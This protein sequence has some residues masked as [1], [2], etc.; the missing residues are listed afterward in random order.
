MYLLRP[1]PEPDHALSLLH[2]LLLLRNRFVP[3]TETTCCE[4]AGHSTPLPSSPEAATNETPLCAKCESCPA[5][6]LHSSPPQL[7]ETTVAPFCTA[8][9]TAWRSE[10]EKSEADSTSMIFA[11]GAMACA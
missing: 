10:L 5:S 4:M 9:S 6:V 2:P 3:P 11:S 1:P 8:T 7:M